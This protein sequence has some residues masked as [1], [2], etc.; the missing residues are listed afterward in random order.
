MIRSLILATALAA[1]TLVLQ[2]CVAGAV[3]GAG[4]VALIADD[5]RT[6]GTYIEDENIEWKALAKAY[7]QFSG[8]HINATSFNRKLLITGEVSTE[9]TKKAVGEAMKAIPSVV[10]IENE[11]AIGYNAS[12]TA[13]GNDSFVTSSVKARLVGNGKV[14]A[15][16]VKV[17]TEAGTVYLMGLVTPAESDAAVEVARSTA[18]VNRVVKV[19]EYVAPK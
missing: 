11:L 13:R 6:T 12:V 3:V 7:D 1:S 2:G 9:E 17:V 15:T 14:S 10:A 4:T 16:H 19:F 5:R 18:G 8:S